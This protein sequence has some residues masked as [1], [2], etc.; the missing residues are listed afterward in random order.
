MKCIRLQR[1]IILLLIGLLAG[2]ALQAEAPTP[3]LPEN[4]ALPPSTEVVE[5]AFETELYFLI[6]GNMI[7]PERRVLTLPPG[8]RREEVVIRAL[9]QGPEDPTLSSAFPSGNLLEFLGVQVCGD[10]CMAYFTFASPAPADIAT[11]SEPVEISDYDLLLSK[12]AIAQSLYAASGIQYFDMYVDNSPTGYRGRGRPLGA[13]QPPGTEVSVTALQ[14]PPSASD[15]QGGQVLETREALLYFTDAEGVLLQ[16][17]ARTQQY[18]IEASLAE[19]LS[20][21]F[22]SLAAGPYAAGSMRILPEDLHHVSSTFRKALTSADVDV[23]S[24]VIHV[25]EE[26]STIQLTDVPGWGYLNLHLETTDSSYDPLLAYASIVHTVTGFLPR[27]LGVRII[28][29]DIPVDPGAVLPE[30]AGSATAKDGYFT[31]GDVSGL[32]GDLVTLCCP[33]KNGLGL[34][35]VSQLLPMPVSADPTQLVQALFEAGEGRTH[36]RW[37]GFSAEDVLGVSVQGSLAVANMRPGFYDKLNTFALSGTWP[38]GQANAAQLAVF[39]IVNTLCTL[40]GVEQVHIL[41]DGAR[42]EKSLGRE[43]DLER[44]YLGNALYE[45]PGLMLS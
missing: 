24:N 13:L 6:A 18:S 11:D 7:A 43:R 38:G 37:Q 10:A 35:P 33:E 14:L 12:A 9:M 1:G 40:P 8:I 5:N 30:I 17:E 44:L 26:A 32:I 20:A 2:C 25:P 31:R 22:D 23:E 42:I 19:I 4:T 15:S 27:L 21:L 28:I 45:N 34:L 41:E 29:N 16:C 39:S 3:P 36:L